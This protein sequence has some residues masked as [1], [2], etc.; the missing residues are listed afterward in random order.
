M[1]NVN[2]FVILI[3]EEPEPDSESE[4][5]QKNQFLKSQPKQPVEDK[6]EFSDSDEWPSTSDSSS[7]SSDDDDNKYQSMREKFLKRPGATHEDDEEKERRKEERRKERKDKDR[8]KVKKEDEDDGDGEGEWETVQRGVAIPSVSFLINYLCSLR[9]FIKF[10]IDVFSIIFTYFFR[11]N[12]KCLLK[13]L[14]LILV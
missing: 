8:R 7:D 6:D 5:P 2:D 12:L 4:A 14:K 13:M 11:R 9:Y 3:I 10:L 1:R